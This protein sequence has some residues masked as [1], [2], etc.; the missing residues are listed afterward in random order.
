MAAIESCFEKPIF[1]DSPYI[2]MNDNEITKKIC[3]V[4]RTD[5]VKRLPRKRSSGIYRR[6]EKIGRSL[7]FSPGKA[8]IS[9]ALRIIYRG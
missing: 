2:L 3:L 1:L 8:Y 7:E 9:A 6:V 5:Q 4:F